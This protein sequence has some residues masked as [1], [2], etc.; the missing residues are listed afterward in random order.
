[1]KV[2]Y[3]DGLRLDV[4]AVLAGKVV[5]VNVGSLNRSQQIIAHFVFL[6]EL[7]KIAIARFVRFY[8]HFPKTLCRIQ[9]VKKDIITQEVLFVFL[10]ISQIQ[11]AVSKQ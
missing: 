7:I 9:S 3:P 4:L 2:R 8:L 1:V 5:L 10:D 6:F 11:L